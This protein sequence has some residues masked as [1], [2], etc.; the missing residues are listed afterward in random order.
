MRIR[1]ELVIFLY[2]AGSSHVNVVYWERGERRGV[3]GWWKD[4]QGG[5]K[6]IPFCLVEFWEVESELDCQITLLLSS[7]S[8]AGLAFGKVRV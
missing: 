4:Y 7:Y 1:C 8:L 6:C 5:E 2:A 3:L